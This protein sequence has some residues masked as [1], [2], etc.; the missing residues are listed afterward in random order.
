MSTFLL[1][2]VGLGLLR[3]LSEAWE[4][5][6]EY[7][8]AS[9]GHQYLVTSMNDLWRLNA[10]YQALITAYIDHLR[11]IYA[12]RPY[13]PRLTIKLWVEINIATELYD[14]KDVSD[15]QYITK[16]SV[17]AYQQFKRDH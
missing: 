17:Q 7:A 15:F 9:V 2:D 16:K 13:W 8:I 6:E 3:Q 4:A 11:F 5:C 12:N 10:E 1:D 14:A